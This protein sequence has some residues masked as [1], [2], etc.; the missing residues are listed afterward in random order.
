M[1]QK[2]SII[3]THNYITIVIIFQ[4]IIFYRYVKVIIL[5]TLLRLSNL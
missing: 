5:S 4:F 2:M 3:R 1:M